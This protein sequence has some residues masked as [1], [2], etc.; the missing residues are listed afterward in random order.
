MLD[1]LTAAV[2]DAVNAGTEG[3]YKVMEAGELLSALEGREKTDEAGLSNAL[4]YLCERGYIDIRY[5]D[6][7]T[8]CL[9]SLPKGRTYAGGKERKEGEGQVL[10]CLFRRVFGRARGLAHRG[11]VGGLSAVMRCRCNTGDVLC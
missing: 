3:S 11:A 9:C 7:G 10:G 2:L 8:Y 1:K 4:K 6:K 5:A